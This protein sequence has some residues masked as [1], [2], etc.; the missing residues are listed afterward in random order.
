VQARGRV[1]A[2]AAFYFGAVSFGWVIAL[3]HLRIECGDQAFRLSVG[4]GAQGMPACGFAF[5]A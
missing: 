2:Q 5:G 3:G 1:D 4:I